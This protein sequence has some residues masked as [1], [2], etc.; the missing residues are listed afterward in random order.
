[1][2]TGFLIAGILAA[3]GIVYLIF[4][5]TL[6][7]G[8][9]AV[10]VGPGGRQTGILAPQPSTNYSGYLAATTAPQV[11]GILNTVLAGVNS[12]F[13]S[14]LSPSNPTPAN[15]PANQGANM[16]SPSLAAQPSGPYPTYGPAAPGNAAGSFSDLQ[17]AF[18]APV[19]P[20]VDPAMSYNATPGSAFDYGPL[21]AD[22]AYDSAASLEV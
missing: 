10:S 18:S 17:A 12:G 19:G 3:V 7:G 22:N 6:L 4:S 9:P 16:A 20:V 14:W 1:M 11:S 21:A 15:A 5:K 8:N 13:H 2:K